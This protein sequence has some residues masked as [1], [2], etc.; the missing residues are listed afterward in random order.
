[1]ALR[2]EEREVGVARAGA[3]DAAVELVAQRLPDRETVG[4]EDD[5]AAHRRIVGKFGAR[6]YFVVPGGEVLAARSDLLFVLFVGHAALS[7]RPEYT[8]PRPK[9]SPRA[10]TAAARSTSI[11]RNVPSRVAAA[12]GVA[13]PRG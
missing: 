2:D 10:L 1:K 7:R 3:L 11:P 5:T 4:T 13:Q 12:P 6:D 8:A 9:A